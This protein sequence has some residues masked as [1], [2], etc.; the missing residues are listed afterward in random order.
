MHGTIEV[1]YWLSWYVF[2]IN[3]K[4]F[5]TIEIVKELMEIGPNEV[6]D[7]NNKS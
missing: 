4:I 2:G 5:E 7:S 6:Y 1:T 3:L